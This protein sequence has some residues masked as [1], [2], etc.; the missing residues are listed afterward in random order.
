MDRDY[1]EN[2]D[3]DGTVTLKR[4]LK[5]KL[6]SRETASCCLDGGQSHAVT[7]SVKRVLQN[8][9]ESVD[10]V[11]KYWHKCTFKKKV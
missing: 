7:V 8:F 3:V 11:G 5:S 6:I 1:L 2:V 10:Y 9:C 4:I